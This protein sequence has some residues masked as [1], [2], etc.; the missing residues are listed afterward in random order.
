[1]RILVDTNTLLSALLFPRG[2]TAEAFDLL[3]QRHRLV[4][5]TYVINEAKTV[6]ER[7]F[8]GYSRALSL[9]L[10]SLDFEVAYTPT[11]I[12]FDS[13]LMRDPKDVPILMTA[14]REDVDII[15]TGDKDF[16]A[17]NLEKPKVL[18]A[19]TFIKRFGQ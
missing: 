18:N 19:K 3:L 16:H 8:P 5:C 4:L 15:L 12:E 2:T 14:I 10:N 6:V 17:L 7:K 13:S 1:M 11:D 9:F